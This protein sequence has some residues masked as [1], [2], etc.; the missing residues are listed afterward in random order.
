MGNVVEGGKMSC[1]VLPSRFFEDR[2][3]SQKYVK[4]FACLATEADPCSLLVGILSVT[5]QFETSPRVMLLASQ[6]HIPS[7]AWVVMASMC[8][9]IWL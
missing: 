9:S 2:D 6:A 1:I 3:D 5:T 8:G 7:L 4:V